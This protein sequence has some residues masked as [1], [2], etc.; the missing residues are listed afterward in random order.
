MNY[1]QGNNQERRQHFL[2]GGAHNPDI[3]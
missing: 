2:Q 1:V 3:K